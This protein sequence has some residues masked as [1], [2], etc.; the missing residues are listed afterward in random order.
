[1]VMPT[2][3]TDVV[4]STTDIKTWELDSTGPTWYM[5]DL[6][7]GPS[8]VS[9]G[10]G[11]YASNAT[12]AFDS[13]RGV[14]VLFGAGP[15]DGS[16]LSEIWEYKA[17]SLGNG[18]GCTAATASSCASGFCVDGVCC[19]TASCSGVCQS[20]SVAGKEG[21]CGLAAPGTEVSGS[22]ADGQACAAGGGCKAQNGTACS[23]ANA[24]ASGVC[25][26]G[27]CCDSPCD[28]T[29]VSCNQV[30]R[31]GKCSPFTA[32][33][34]PQNECGLGSD[35]CRSTCNGAGACDYP[36]AGTPCGPCQVCD[37][38]GVCWLDSTPYLCNTGGTG[39]GGA[40]GSGG[41]GGVG[42]SGI[43]G[44]GGAGGVATGGGSIIGGT[45][46][47][48]AGGTMVGGTMVGG[49]G[50]LGS[51]GSGGRGSAGGSIIGGTMVG[52]AGGL[53]SGGSGG[54]GGSGVAGTI[55]GGAGAAG[56]VTSGASGGHAGAISGGANAGGAG[57][58]TSG[59]AGGQAGTISGGAGG[60]PDAG[61]DSIP[62]DAGSPDGRRDARPP[63]AGSTGRL[64][65]K[66]CDCDLGHTPADGPGLPFALLSAALFWRRVRRR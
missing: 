33:S 45:M 47:G 44:A 32:G 4:G 17:T 63:D 40:G 28:G 51:G 42:G 18:E 56:G 57:G 36:Q 48:G 64:G 20:C 1:M 43:G 61:R 9:T 7:T 21:T 2:N 50:G 65:H 3:A 39:G 16:A 8:T 38:N 41:A 49:A 34:D 23:S 14:M 5:R 55:V 58:V 10:P 22:C 13:Q 6:A 37:G 31:T 11:W 53:G 30:G 15:D 26:D 60:S 59:G 27:V 46:V 25:A 35:V 62:P 52:G 12:M 54:R 24:C 19:S 66:G 29:C